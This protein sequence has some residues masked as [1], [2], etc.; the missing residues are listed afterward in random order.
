MI[1][2]GVF[3]SP[4]RIQE[5][6]AYTG[7]YFSPKSGF[8]KIVFTPGLPLT[9]QPLDNVKRTILEEVIFNIILFSN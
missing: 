4:I 2:T 3:F 8:T 1:Y 5:N 6:S 7:V 9:G